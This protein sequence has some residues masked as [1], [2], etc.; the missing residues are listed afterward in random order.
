MRREGEPSGGFELD[1]FGAESG[2]QQRG[3]VANLVADFE[4]DQIG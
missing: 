2:K 4:N 3:V 1:H